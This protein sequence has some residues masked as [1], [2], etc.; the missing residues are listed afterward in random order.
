VRFIGCSYHERLR[1]D[2]SIAPSTTT[3]LL[4]DRDVLDGDA[5]KG[6]K[7]DRTGAAAAER[8]DPRQPE[9]GDSFELSVRQLVRAIDV[10]VE[11]VDVGGRRADVELALLVYRD[12]NIAATPAAARAWSNIIA[13][14][15]FVM[16]DTAILS[17]PDRGDRCSS[18]RSLV[19]SYA[20]INTRRSSRSP[21]DSRSPK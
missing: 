15:T 12:A 10:L 3:G 8:D 1:S 6:R 5:T 11:D 7:R 9:R 13:R 21:S 2:H 14:M 16:L 17:A 19:T 18:P 20:A 4:A